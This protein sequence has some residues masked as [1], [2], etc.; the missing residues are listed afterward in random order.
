MTPKQW[1]EVGRIFDAATALQPEE[2]S[3]F[4][5]KVCGEDESLRREVQSLLP[6]CGVIWVKT[7]QQCEEVRKHQAQH[8]D[9]R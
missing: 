4:L 8:N 6:D 7:H 5:D 1:E 2:R 3:S 9:R